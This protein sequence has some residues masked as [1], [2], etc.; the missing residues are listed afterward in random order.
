MGKRK[1][2]DDSDEDHMLNLDF[3]R[4]YL[5]REP[6]VRRDV[7]DRKALNQE[8]SC[9]V[10]KSTLNKFTKAAGLCIR[11]PLN[12][13][14]REVNRT[15][16]EAYMLANLHVNRMIREGH[17]LGELDQS[18]FYGCLSAVSVAGRR[19]TEIKDAHFR[20]S[21]Q[22]YSSWAT[23]CPEHWPPNSQYLASGFHQQ[24]SLQMATNTRVAVSENFHRRFKR[25]LRHKHQLDGAQAWTMLRQILGESY[26][27]ED[28]V[29]IQYRQRMPR[30]PPRGRAEEQPHLVLPLMREFL[31]YF[32]SQH[33]GERTAKALRLFSLVP[34]KAGFECTHVK[35]C[36]NGLYGLLKRAG[37]EELPS[38][39]P[40]WRAAAPAFWRRI[41]NID[42]FETANRKFA[43]EILTDGHSVSIVMRKPRAPDTCE[44]RPSNLDEHPDILGLDPG[45]TDLFT[46]CDLQGEHRHYST[47]RFREEATYN[48]SQRTMAG[49]IDRCEL[50]KRVCA[51]LPS[52]KTSD[53]DGLKRHIQYV[54]PVMDRML[55]WHMEKPF[56]KLKLRRYIASKKTLKAIC[57]E[58][59]A[60]AGRK[61]LIGFGDWSNIDSA[62][63]IKKS[64]AGPVKKL[65]AELR[66]RCRVVSVDEFRTSKLHS[67]CGCQLRNAYRHKHAKKDE[68][69]GIT[70]GEFE[71]VVKIHKVL[72]CANS[73]CSGI[74]MD[75]DENASLNILRLLILQ[76]Q[77]FD[78]PPPFCR[79][80]DLPAES[81]AAPFG[82]VGV[83]PGVEAQASA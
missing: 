62:G 76:T 37:L 19:K 35:L 32:E 59:T 8:T 33:A 65:Q 44:H 43:G 21:V 18:F 52:R 58:L 57:D 70:G 46:T 2:P 64:P 16:A 45:R 72:C 47:K 5:F 31:A 22:L 17:P 30:K 82:D 42:K 50:A 25:Y 80:V 73:S 24:A 40:S 75:R 38:E 11:T 14:V 20:D 63:I 79:G 3:A 39:G 41:F 23:D 9:S 54:L 4:K 83:W 28:H 60:R 56:R 66:K 29:I 12:V 78:R 74:C 61:T 34:N 55:T 48:A 68:A 69:N 1:K 6:R 81:V 7:V 49:W 36:T 71:R 10:V 67:A 51:E 15:V 13:I 53:L 26:D 27:G 77:G